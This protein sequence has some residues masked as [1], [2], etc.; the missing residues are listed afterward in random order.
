MLPEM[1]LHLDR[2][3]SSGK[4]TKNPRYFSKEESGLGYAGKLVYTHVG[5]PLARA[6]AP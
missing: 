6:A 1:K 4:P 2:L 5:V 3:L